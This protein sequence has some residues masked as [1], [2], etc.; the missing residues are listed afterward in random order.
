MF[1]T[2][3]HLISVLTGKW[4]GDFFREHLWQPMGMD[5]TY[6]SL[7]DAEGSGLVLAAEYYYDPSSG[8]HFEVPHERSSGEQGA[9]GIISTVLDYAKYLRVMIDESAPLSKAG[10]REVKT[11]RNFVAP[12]QAPYVGAPTY[13]LGWGAAVFEGEQVY[14]HSGQV[15]MFRSTMRIVP[16]RRL[17][18]AV[19][20]NTDADV[21]EILAHHV[22]SEHLGVPEDKRYDLNKR[23]LSERKQGLEYLQ[24]C[25]K[26]LYPSLPDPPYLP[27]LP[28]PEHVGDFFDP[29]YGTL[30]VDLNCSGLVE[31]CKL[32]ILGVG[33]DVHAYLGPAVYLEPMSGNSWLGRIAYGAGLVEKVAV[34]HECVPV[35]FRIDVQGKV[36]HVGVGVRLED[37]RPLT[38]FERV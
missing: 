21:P 5:E 19:F 10:H 18:V 26:S 15:T 24:N 36:S 17:G 33:G 31:N 30:R 9:G 20:I 7:A 11:P 2:M 28:V 13:A 16:S 4:L 14:S 38:W 23:L 29:G 6:F 32:R 3:G 8:K 27:T 22:L 35:E 34:I 12:S 25:A 1:V 37:G